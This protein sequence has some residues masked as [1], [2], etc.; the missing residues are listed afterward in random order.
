MQQRQAKPKA[1]ERPRIVDLI[2]E[3]LSL[4][5]ARPWLIIVPLLVD[6]FIWLGVKIEPSALMN[7]LI[8]LVNDAGL[9]DTEDVITTLQDLATANMTHLIAI[10]VPSMLRGTDDSDVYQLLDQRVW[11]PSSGAVLLV[12]LALI[13]VSSLLSMVYTVPIANAIVGRK[14]TLGENVGLMLRSWARMLLFIG[15][16]IGALMVVIVPTAV[17]SA[18]F[19]PLLPLFSSLLLIGALAGLVLLYF[20]FDAIVIADVGPIDAIKFSA[21]I[22]RRNLGPAMALILA[23]LLLTTGVPEIATRILDNLPGLIIAV[24][25]QAL[26]ATGLAAASMFFFVDRLRKLRPDL[27]KLPQT[28]PA[29]DLTR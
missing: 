15:I 13:F 27:V 25:V 6:L 11:T 20:V 24:A 4:V 8:E 7:S 10:F 22:V 14:L 21:Q 3:G 12:A 23:S 28:A 26:V 5:L 29:F 18:I 19:A 2:A 1:D 9:D 16:V 17:I